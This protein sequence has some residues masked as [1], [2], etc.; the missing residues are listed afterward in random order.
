MLAPLGL[1]LLAL[2]GAAQGSRQLCLDEEDPCDHKNPKHDW[3]AFCNTFTG[4]EV[5][6]SLRL[7]PPLALAWTG[8]VEMAQFHPCV[9]PPHTTAT[10]AS[11][12]SPQGCRA[13]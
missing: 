5:S 4:R 3:T 1:L 6:L 8:G 9:T 2:A 13:A 11:H 12:S 10:S 7:A